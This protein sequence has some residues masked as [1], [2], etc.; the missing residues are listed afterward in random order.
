MLKVYL[1]PLAEKKLSLLLEHIEYEW[2]KKERDDFL[3]KIVNSFNRVANHPESSP[4]SQTFP[5]LF[6]CVVSKQTSFFYRFNSDDL[7]IITVFDNRQD[8]KK[9]ETEIEKFFK[10]K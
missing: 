5:D 10:H 2:A 3:E 6:K 1:S 7:E 4:K 8:P 9:I